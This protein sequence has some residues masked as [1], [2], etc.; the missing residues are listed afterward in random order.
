[1][2]QS[3]CYIERSR[4]GAVALMGWDD[5]KIVSFSTALSLEDNRHTFRS[6]GTLPIA[7]MIRPTPSVTRSQRS[8]ISLTKIHTQPLRE[9]PS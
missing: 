6:W 8:R 2:V 4:Q 3:H 5:R 7:N 9:L 1:M